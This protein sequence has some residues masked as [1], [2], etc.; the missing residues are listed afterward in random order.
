MS[1][2]KAIKKKTTIILGDQV[3]PIVY[4]VSAMSYSITEAMHMTQLYF[5]KLPCY[6]EARGG[7]IINQ[8]KAKIVQP[9]HA[10]GTQYFKIK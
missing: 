3:S 9:I 8:N 1:T 7:T 6:A 10:G 2:A 4:D 5:S